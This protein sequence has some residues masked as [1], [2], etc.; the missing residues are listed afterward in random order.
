MLFKI[1]AARIFPPFLIQYVNPIN[2]NKSQACYHRQNNW[3]SLE[4]PLD[5]GPNDSF[6]AWGWNPGEGRTVLPRSQPERG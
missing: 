3:E 5:N 2:H 4:A 6:G 1:K